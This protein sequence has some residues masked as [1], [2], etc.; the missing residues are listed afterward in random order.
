MAAQWPLYITTVGAFLNDPAEGRTEKDVAEKLATEYKKAVTTVFTVAPAG[1]NKPS[2]LPSINPMKRAIRKSLEDIKESE[3]EP[4]L[5]HFDKWASEV[6]KFW[7]KTKFS[8]IVPDPLHLAAATGI[9]GV[10]LPIKNVVLNGGVLPALQADLLT[11]FTNPPSP[12]P[13]GIPVAGKLAKAFT[14]HLTTV[15]GTHTMA[16]TSGTPLSPIP[17]PA[18]PI[19]WIQLV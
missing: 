9:P 4:K 3:G 7:L 13:N 5:F 11:A 1:I 10:T 12:V 17:I 19:P 18:L 6:T 8:T 16:V 2:Q 14:T 15:G